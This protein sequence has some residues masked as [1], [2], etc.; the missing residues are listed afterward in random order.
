MAP[1]L[2]F[3]GGGEPCALGEDAKGEPEG[4]LDDALEL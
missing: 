3:G 4:L 1:K 2:K